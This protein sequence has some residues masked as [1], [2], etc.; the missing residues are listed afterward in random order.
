MPELHGIAVPVICARLGNGTFLSA[1]VLRRRIP[2]M[3]NAYLSKRIVG[4]LSSSSLLNMHLSC[5]LLSLCYGSL[6]G[7]PL[8]LKLLPEVL[9]IAETPSSTFMLD[10]CRCP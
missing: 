8:L 1:A 9:H 3:R 6:F 5:K 7:L 10:V 2:E 4:S